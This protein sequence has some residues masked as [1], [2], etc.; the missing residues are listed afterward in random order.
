[1]AIRAVFERQRGDV[2][3]ERHLAHCGRRGRRWLLSGTACGGDRHDQ[4]GDDRC[5]RQGGPWTPRDR[6]E[7]PMTHVCLHQRS[8]YLEDDEDGR[9]ELATCVGAEQATRHLGLF[10][11]SA[12]AQRAL[13]VAATFPALETSSH[14]DGNVDPAASPRRR[15][16]AVTL[17]EIRRISVGNS[18]GTR[19]C[20][21]VVS[22]LLSIGKC[23]G[24]IKMHVLVPTG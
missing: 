1:M 12:G 19:R 9:V 13:P 11:E 4:E 7:S 21:A 8:G 18:P 20:V 15:D 10:A 24:L 6:G 3:R 2:L 16:A 5:G 23:R 22:V 17:C 14:I